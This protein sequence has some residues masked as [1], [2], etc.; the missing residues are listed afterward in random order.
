MTTIRR[1]DFTFSVFDRMKNKE[2]AVY[3][4]GTILKLLENY[5]LKGKKERIKLFY[6][7]TVK[8]FLEETR[9]FDENL[10]DKTWNL[11]VPKD[12]P[13]YAKLVSDVFELEETIFYD[14]STQD[15]IERLMKKYSKCCMLPRFE[16]TYVRFIADKYIQESVLNEITE[17]ISGDVFYFVYGDDL[18]DRNSKGLVIDNRDAQDCRTLTVKLNV[19]KIEADGVD[20]SMLMED[21]GETAKFVEVTDEPE[22]IITE[23]KNYGEFKITQPEIKTYNIGVYNGV[24]LSDLKA[25]TVNDAIDQAVSKD[26]F[27]DIHVYR[28]QEIVIRYKIDLSAL[29][30]KVKGDL[31]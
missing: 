19:D 20:L 15:D 21:V 2:S 23:G 27:I 12:H 28:G 6:S 18:K 26:P 13:N 3:F 31:V 24:K 17:C 10:W 5:H 29:L 9:A 25:R 1:E 22:P 7:E 16:K 14:D 4:T 11:F 30:K 8:K